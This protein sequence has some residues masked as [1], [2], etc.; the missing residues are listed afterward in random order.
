MS[1]DVSFIQGSKEN[2]NPS[3]MAGGVFFSKDTKEIL[4]NGESYGNSVKADEED[5]TAES[6]NLK[7]K[8]RAYDEASFSGKGYVI[9]RKNIQESKNI[10]TQDMINQDNTIYEIRYDFDLNEQTITIPEG[11]ILKF[12]GGKL[13]NGIINHNQDII[14]SVNHDVLTN[15]TNNGTYIWS[16]HTPNVYVI[17]LDKFGITPGYFEKDQNGHYT[18]EQY[19]LMYN[20]GLG[21][22]NAI[23]YAYEQN[24]SGIIL[25]RNTY[26]FCCRSSESSYPSPLILVQDIEKFL[27]L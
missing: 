20:N 21:I 19:N 6:G 25:P 8:D 13:C 10:L 26:C 16:N 15:I 9:L 1:E 14:D 18:Q 17:D 24:Y 23:N 4:L 7:L 5:I 27:Y 22:T 3:E 12:N 11:C 2:Y